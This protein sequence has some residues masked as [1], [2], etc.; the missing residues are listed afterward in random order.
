MMNAERIGHL[1]SIII[2]ECNTFV[3]TADLRQ[4]DK[5]NRL[6]VKMNYNMYNTIMRYGSVFM[7]HF[8]CDDEL[9]I[10]GYLNATIP[11]ILSDELEDD[12]FTI[13]Y[14]NTGISNTIHIPRKDD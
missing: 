11:V 14:E 10:V 4:I 13:F 1:V 5:H 3:C 9:K 7:H 12:Y 2:R 8:D 6:C